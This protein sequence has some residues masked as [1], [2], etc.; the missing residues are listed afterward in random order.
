MLPKYFEGNL[1]AERRFFLFSLPP[2]EILN[3][4]QSFC[5]LR[6][7]LVFC[8]PVYLSEYFLW[9][10]VE[11]AFC[12]N[13]FF[14]NY[15]HRYLF[16]QQLVVILL[17]TDIFTA[18]L[19]FFASVRKILYNFILN[20]S[21]SFILH[22]GFCS[23]IPSCFFLPLKTLRACLC[24]VYSFHLTRRIKENFRSLFAI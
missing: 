23:A 5:L 7:R 2:E 16:T 12:Q 6:A 19:C 14:P 18:I 9:R 22:N 20:L 8:S 15:P 21:H 3:L 10:V 17:I 13:N 4:C 24:A 11:T 1:G